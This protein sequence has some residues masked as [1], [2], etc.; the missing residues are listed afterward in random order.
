MREMIGK[1]FDSNPSEK[2][3]FQLYVKNMGLCLYICRVG[4]SRGGLVAQILLLVLCPNNDSWEAKWK[5]KG[6]QK[7][8][9][10]NICRGYRN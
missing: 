6:S 9:N 10:K 4:G 2:M 1:W 7:I 8:I 5:E 3:F